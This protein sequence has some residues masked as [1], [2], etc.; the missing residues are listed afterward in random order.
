MQGVFSTVSGEAEDPTSDPLITR[1]PLY[2][3]SHDAR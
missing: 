3:Q 2:V 1:Q